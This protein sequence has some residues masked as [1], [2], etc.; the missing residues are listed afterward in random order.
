M[1]DMQPRNEKKAY[2]L[3]F[4]TQSQSICSKVSLACPV[5]VFGF[6]KSFGVPEDDVGTPECLVSVDF[7]RF[8][9]ELL[10]NDRISHQ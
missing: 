9:R 7:G 4:G 2:H 3:L 6:L 10:L 1:Y 8:D 5:P